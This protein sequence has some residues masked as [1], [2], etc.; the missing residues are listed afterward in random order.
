MF[1]TQMGRRDQLPVIC[2]NGKICNILQKQ[3]SFFHN[4]NKASDRVTI[5][6]AQ[7]FFI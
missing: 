2:R 4:D 6:L 1:K 3:L 7:T 5:L